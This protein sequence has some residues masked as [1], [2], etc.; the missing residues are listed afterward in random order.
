M[1]AN[2]NRSIIKGGKRRPSQEVGHWVHRIATPSGGPTSQVLPKYGRPPILPLY[3]DGVCLF[4][5]LVADKAAC[6]RATDGTQHAAAQ[7]RSRR[8]ADACT[9]GGVTLTCRHAAAGR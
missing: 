8:A 1:A 4:T 9:N 7:R 2:V 6:R 3:A 5:D